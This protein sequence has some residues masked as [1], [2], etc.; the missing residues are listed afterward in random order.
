M[1]KRI[2]SLVLVVVLLALYL[3][4]FVIA[5]FTDK[6]SGGLFMACLFT[7]VMFPILLYGYQLIL[8]VLQTKKTRRNSHRK[9]KE[10]S[11]GFI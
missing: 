4:T 10:V 8:K 6:D 9:R 11:N 7:T 5:C 3:T 1:K 2:F